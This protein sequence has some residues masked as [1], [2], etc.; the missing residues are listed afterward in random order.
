MKRA[1]GLELSVFQ[2]FLIDQETGK[3]LKMS[4]EDIERFKEMTK[5]F[6]KK[7]V[8]AAYWINLASGK[9][10]GGQHILKREL[11][12]AETLGYDGVVL[13]P[14]SAVGQET[15]EG[16]IAAIVRRLNRLLKNSSMT[17][18]LENTAHGNR[19]IGGSLEDLKSIRDQV[20]K[21]IRL[22]FASI[23]LMLIHMA[24]IWVRKKE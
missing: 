11:A 12:L 6:H 4:P 15:K 21:K 16:G 14:G 8:H 18:L 3:K 1:E 23:R 17:I 20:E 13:H 2:N 19:S 10:F 22:N 5:K 7:F 9:T 24:M